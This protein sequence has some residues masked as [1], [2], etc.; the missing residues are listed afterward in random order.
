[1]RKSYWVYILASQA[2]VLYVGVTNDLARRVAEHRAG[3]GSTFTQR[4]HVHRLVYAEEYVD[5]REAIAREKAVKGWR[6]AR[7]LDLIATVN[8][9][10]QDWGDAPERSPLGRQDA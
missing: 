10:W 2:R 9:E 8:P 5:V 4:Y 3:H 6:R 1:M 7:K